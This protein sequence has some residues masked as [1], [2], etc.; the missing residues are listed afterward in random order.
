MTVRPH[1]IYLSVAVALVVMGSTA[2]YPAG[3]DDTRD[4]LV[5]QVAVRDDP[6]SYNVLASRD[7]VTRNALFP[8]YSSVGL[9][10]PGNWELIPYILKGIDADDNGVFDQDEYGVFLKEEGANP[11]EVTAYYDLNWIY[12]HDGVQATV[13]DLL[14][15]YHL[16]ALRPALEPF[17]SSLSILKDQK[18]LPGSNYSS[19]HWLW[20][21]PVEDVWDPNIE[22][23]ANSSLTIALRFEMQGT[24]ASFA[25]FTLSGLRLFP[26]HAWE[27][28][29]RYCKQ[30]EDHV[31]A[32]WESDIHDDFGC[33]YDPVTKNGVPTGDPNAF[34]L[35]EAMQWR[36][37]VQHVIGT[38]PFRLLGDDAYSHARYARFEDYYAEA[39]DKSGSHYMHMPY[40]DGMLYKVFKT[41]HAAVFAL[42]AGEVDVT[43]FAVAP[44]F[45]SG[46]L[47]DP[48]IELEA[49]AEKGFTYLGYNMRSSPFGYP[50]NDPAR[51]D[52]GLHLRKAIA[53]SL[54]KRNMVTVILQN[55][56]ARGD[57]PVSPGFTRWYNASVPKYEYDLDAA[58]QMLDH[59]YTIDGMYNPSAPDPL[60][61]GP[62]GYR[63]LPSIDDGPIEIISYTMDFDP[64][65]GGSAAIIAGDLMAIGLNVTAKTLSHAEVVDRVNN[66]GLQ[67][68]VTHQGI[69]SDPPIYYYDLF[70]SIHAPYGRNFAGFQ[71]DTVDELLVEAYGEDD[72]SRQAELIKQTS[73]LLVDALP[74]D[75]LFFQTSIEAYR[76]DRFT[77]WT[78][79]MSGSII[80][81][82]FWSL[83]GIRPPFKRDL[84]VSLSTPS[85][86]VSMSKETI[87]AVVSDLSG[88]TVSGARVH[89]CLASFSM[90]WDPGNLTTNGQNGTCVSVVTGVN[91]AVHAIYQAPDLK[92]LERLEVQI[93]AEARIGFRVSSRTTTFFTIYPKAKQ[94]LSVRI[95]M[96]TGDVLPIGYSIL[97]DVMVTDQSVTPLSGVRVNLT[98][99]PDGLTFEPA[100]G[101]TISGSIGEIVV[102]P[103]STMQGSGDFDLYNIV[104][105][106]EM[107]DYGNGS[108]V[109]EVVVL[110]L[111]S[112]PPTTQSDGLLTD[113]GIWSAVAVVGAVVTLSA[114]F[115]VRRYSVRRRSE[116]RR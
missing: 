46:L 98:S 72:L 40:I 41:A 37:E 11:L 82:S 23:G 52:D 36:P 84:V 5:L 55:F 27:G 113:I 79:G 106:A 7:D 53:H 4:E 49:T 26:R 10:D 107:E 116:K 99:V 68:W 12:F 85:A 29:G 62:S 110:E 8:V 104:A 114:L 105:A 24:Y 45:V 61:Y 43:A 64:R 88:T 86:M 75:V 2:V 112:P 15:S 18:G 22:V 57:Q 34:H 115:L 47:L 51:G 32:E 81:E 28:T 19:T 33:A 30:T 42:Q 44:E 35:S 67:M 70:H 91:G 60:G 95:N 83:I 76:S 100:N 74:V 9:Y 25:E 56:G 77:N 54:D 50:D 39:V 31:C 58:R 1:A 96:Q 20:V 59:Y 89:L 17:V 103:P 92:D 48:N 111:S 97:V 63:R 66:R 21:H 6:S 102:T 94:F 93:S 87:R 73:G 69:S 90:E 14:F 109:A 78:M 65:R 71:N 80:R 13:E 3:G 38:G 101:T 108:A 16:E